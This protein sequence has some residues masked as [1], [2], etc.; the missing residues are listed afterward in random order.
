VKAGLKFAAALLLIILLL[1]T[2]AYA[3][4]AWYFTQIG[5]GTFAYENCGPACAVMAVKWQDPEFDGSVEDARKT[6]KPNGGGWSVN[7]IICYLT[8]NDARGC[9]KRFPGEDAIADMLDKAILILLVDTGQLVY[10]QAS[11]TGHFIIV[12]AY[13][14]LDEQLYLLIND[15][16]QGENILYTYGDIYDAVQARCILCIRVKSGK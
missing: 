13:E 10:K 6:Y 11:G 3:D 15:P 5:T 2:T 7:E 14:V 8:G 9:L 16:W 1:N 4:N 12:K